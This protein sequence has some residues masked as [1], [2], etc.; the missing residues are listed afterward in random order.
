MSFSRVAYCFYSRAKEVRSTT[1]WGVIFPCA[2]PLRNSLSR[3]LNLTCQQ[4]IVTFYFNLQGTTRYK[5]FGYKDLLPAYVGLFLSAVWYNITTINFRTKPIRGW[6]SRFVT[7]HSAPEIFSCIY[8]SITL[9]LRCV[10]RHLTIGTVLP[11]STTLLG[12]P[13]RSVASL[14]SAN[15]DL[16]CHVCWVWH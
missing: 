3:R 5:G 6:I 8:G 2:I 7:E 11:P 14:N 9:H 12:V 16:Y 10:G 1:A 13:E 15:S 4:T